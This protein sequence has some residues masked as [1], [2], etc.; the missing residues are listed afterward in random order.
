MELKEAIA[1]RSINVICLKQFLEIENELR[2]LD[3]EQIDE[4]FK[5]IRERIIPDKWTLIVFSESF[6]GDKEPLNSDGVEYIV[7]KCR[8]LTKNFPKAVMHISFLHQFNIAEAHDWLRQYATIPAKEISNR[9]INTEQHAEFLQAK[10]VNPER[11]TNYSLV[12]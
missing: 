7:E 6:F 8:Q 3:L 11:V 2:M 4:I 5:K 12:I 1:S 9:L 10:E